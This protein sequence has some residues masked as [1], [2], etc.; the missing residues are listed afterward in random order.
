[1]A[2]RSLYV[3][4]W[5]IKAGDYIESS[6]T[7]IAFVCTNSITQG[8]QVAQLWP[9][10]FDRCNLEIAFAHQT[11]AWGS[12]ARRKAHVHVAVIGL[13]HRKKMAKVEKRL[14]SYPDLK[15]QPDENKHAA[16][17]PYL[18]AVDEIGDPHLTVREESKP[19]NG[20][21]ALIIGSQPI[22]GGNFIFDEQERAEFLK[23][24]PDAIDYLR[25]F[26]GA[27][28][29]L[30]GDKR[31]ILALH[32]APPD[33][34]ASM[35]IVRE[36]IAAVRV[37]RQASKSI[38]TQKLANFSTQYHVNVLPTE[39]FLAIPVTSSVR[40]NYV[41]ISWLKPPVIPSNSIRVLKNGTLIDFA[42]LS[43]AMHMAWMR[44]VGGRLKTDFRYSIGLV[45]NTFPMPSKLTSKKTS[46]ARL[47]NYAQ[48]VLDARKDHPQ[49]TLAELYDPELMPP[50]LRKA[51]QSL[52]RAVDRLYSPTNFASE[53]ARVAHLF[54][55]YEKMLAP[56]K[57]NMKLK[58]TR[59]RKQQ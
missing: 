24:E 18:F 21:Q 30:N 6:N 39:K 7:R 28:E 9:I 11:F 8:E 23:T 41:P 32:D 45:Y 42:L 20:M 38:L 53:G 51:H 3:A 16:I 22:D 56:L 5:F 40:R 59:R 27:R 14:F 19:I 25:P 1:M 29:L 31:W 37:Y 17:S 44:Y 46:L 34:L 35:S 33:K 10:L 26:V 47:K 36:R 12:D 52:D 55:L 15:G 48:S 58:Q 43:S 57:T 2:A 4:A 54:M 49:A 50:N 13:D